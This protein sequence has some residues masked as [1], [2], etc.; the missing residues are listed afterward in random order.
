MGSALGSGLTAAFG[1]TA[2]DFTYLVPLILV[3]YHKF[4]ASMV[5]FRYMWR[6]TSLAHDPQVFSAD[7]WAV[8]SACL[9][10]EWL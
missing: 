6:G 7:C 3:C 10:L 9:W 4:H 5:Y 2:T 1:V 8:C